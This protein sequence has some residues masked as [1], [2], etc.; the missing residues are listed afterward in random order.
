MELPQLL[1]S[2]LYYATA[3]GVCEI[4]RRLG[5]R[6]APSYSWLYIEFFATVQRCLL[7]LEGFAIYKAYGELAFLVLVGATV[8]LQAKT[9]R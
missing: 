8:Y 2:A 7:T 3:V 1:V 9:A 4:G 5:D 6:I